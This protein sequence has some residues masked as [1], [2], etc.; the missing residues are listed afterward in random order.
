MKIEIEV[1]ES[2][3]TECAIT[4]WRAT[5]A[6]PRYE[7][8][9]GAQGWETVKAEVVRQVCNIDVSELV[10][11]AVAQF[12]PLIVRDVVQ[13]ELK[14]AI[15]EAARVAAKSADLFEQEKPGHIKENYE[16]I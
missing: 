2:V 6:A 11:K 15:K 14:K 4:A 13:Q 10:Q 3:I 5:F 7:S 16:T 12:T 8:D 9:R 1:P